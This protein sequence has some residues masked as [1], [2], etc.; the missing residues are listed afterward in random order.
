MRSSNGR[1][2]YCTDTW[3]NKSIGRSPFTPTTQTSAHDARRPA[4]SHSHLLPHRLQALCGSFCVHIFPTVRSWLYTSAC[5]IPY[6]LIVN[7]PVF[8]ARGAH[9]VTSTPRLRFMNW[10]WERFRNTD[11]RNYPRTHTRTYPPF[12]RCVVRRPL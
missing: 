11:R 12:A 9:H 1:S 6:T 10:G 5:I 7:A 2:R 8:T 3:R 4:R